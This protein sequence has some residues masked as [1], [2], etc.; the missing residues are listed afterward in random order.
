MNAKQEVELLK[1][2][3]RIATGIESIGAALTVR[4]SEQ[5]KGEVVGAEVSD[6]TLKRLMTV[7]KLRKKA[8]DR[9]A[10]AFG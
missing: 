1:L 2:L 5:V 10:K 7:E 4:V 3:G 8:L 6:K 9:L